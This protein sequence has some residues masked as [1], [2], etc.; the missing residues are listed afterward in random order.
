MQEYDIIK[1]CF[2][3]RKGYK[4]KIDPNSQKAQRLIEGGFIKAKEEPKAPPA[5]KRKKKVI[6][7]EETK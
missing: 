2:I 7:P 6:K 1:N 4:V 5:I 3:G